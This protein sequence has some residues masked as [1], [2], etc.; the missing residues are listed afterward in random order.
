MGAPGD[1]K[2]LVKRCHQRGI[3]VL[4]DVV[5]NHARDCP[6]ARPAWHRDLIRREEPGRG[7]DYG[8]QMIRYREPVD[9]RHWARLLHQDVARHLIEEYHVDG[10]GRPP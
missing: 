3:R 1:L 7:E 6:L 10:F 4:I 2:W 8:G 5:M 9:G